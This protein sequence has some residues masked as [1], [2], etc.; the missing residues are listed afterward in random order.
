MEQPRNR[1]PLLRAHQMVG[2]LRCSLGDSSSEKTAAKTYTNKHGQT[3]TMNT[4]NIAKLDLLGH[5]AVGLHGPD[6]ACF[7]S[8]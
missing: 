7:W 6:V 3:A 1:A 8:S 5:R 4:E 2:H